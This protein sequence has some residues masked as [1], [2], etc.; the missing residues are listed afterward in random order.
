MAYF[1]SQIGSTIDHA[2]NQALSK[3]IGERLQVSFNQQTE[4]SPHLVSLLKRLRLSE[5]N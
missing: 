1:P 4:M 2:S 5:V 3:A